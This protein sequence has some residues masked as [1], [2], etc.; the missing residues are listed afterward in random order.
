MHPRGFMAT[1]KPSSRR[2]MGADR[3]VI[4]FRKIEVSQSTVEVSSGCSL[5]AVAAK[6]RALGSGEVTDTLQKPWLSFPPRELD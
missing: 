1:E 2:Q 6:P 5:P 4:C 3:H